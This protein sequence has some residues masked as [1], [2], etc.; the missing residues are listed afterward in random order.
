MMIE[1]CVELLEQGKEIWKDIVGYEGLYKVSNLGNIYSYKLGRNI[2]TQK[3][4]RGY[5]Q[6]HLSKDGKRKYIHVHQLVAS[7][8]IFFVPQYNIKYEVNHIDE[9]K[10]NNRVE[11][12]EYITHIKNN[13]YGT[14]N[15]RVSKT[16]GTPVRCIETGIIYHS[17]EEARRQTNVCANDISKCCKGI[18]KSAKKL[19][20]EYV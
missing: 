12:L 20:W 14:R 3:T 1:E 6:A 7:H 18:R 16:M 15:N 8:F 13:N 9:D 2:K 11:N 10:L 5:L 4:T 17:I 19:H